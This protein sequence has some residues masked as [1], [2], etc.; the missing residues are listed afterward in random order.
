MP[1]GRLRREPSAGE[2]GPDSG[3]GEQHQPALASGAQRE[4]SAVDDESYA[5][6]GPEEPVADPRFAQQVQH[7]VRGGEHHDGRRDHAAYT[8]VARRLGRA[9]WWFLAGHLP[10]YRGGAA[11]ECPY[12]AHRV[13][14]GRVQTADDVGGGPGLLR[15]AGVGKFGTPSLQQFG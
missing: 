3:K 6:H 2:A 10:P 7:Q 11:L 5:H 15:M 1:S 13:L 9:W 14:P 12:K 4:G 8:Q